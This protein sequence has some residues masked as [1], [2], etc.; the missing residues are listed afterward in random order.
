MGTGSSFK[1]FCKTCGVAVRNE[2]R[3]LSDE[4][5]AKLAEPVQRINKRMQEFSP[6]NIRLL[7]DFDYKTLKTRQLDGVSFNNEHAPYVNP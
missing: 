3:T 5:F 2:A 4:E 6:I 1:P 7:D